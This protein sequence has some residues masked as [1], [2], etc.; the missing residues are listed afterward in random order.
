MT[1]TC[2]KWGGEIL[3]LC[4]PI[5]VVAPVL[6]CSELVV[7][8]TSACRRDQLLV[9]PLTLFLLEPSMPM[10]PVPVSM[11]LTTP[12]GP[13][14]APL[15]MRV[16]SLRIPWKAGHTGTSSRNHPLDTPLT[17]IICPPEDHMWVPLVGHMGDP[18]ITRVITGSPPTSGT[19]GPCREE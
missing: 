17:T 8:R 3:P 7:W 14:H 13:G 12:L 1:T 15:T 19:V 9:P 11:T 18:I 10:A 16:V 2:L 6:S 5:A 4:H